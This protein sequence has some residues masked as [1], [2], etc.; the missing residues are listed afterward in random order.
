MPFYPRAGQTA[1]RQH[2]PVWIVARLLQM[3]DE[4]NHYRSLF[5]TD[6]DSPL[7]TPRV[8]L[9]NVFESAARWAA[10]TPLLQLHRA[11]RNEA[12]QK[13]SRHARPPSRPSLPALL[14]QESLLRCLRNGCGSLFDPQQDE[15]AQALRNVPVLR[16]RFQ[17][18]PW[19]PGPA[20]SMPAAR[21]IVDTCDVFQGVRR[22]EKGRGTHETSIYTRTLWKC[23]L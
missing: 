7:L 8:L 5:V 23:S 15:A 20:P 22:T 12:Q 16:F 4:E 2:P 1:A 19:C 10:H 6:R 3:R 14:L 17:F 9:I 21:T 13:G 18:P 11:N